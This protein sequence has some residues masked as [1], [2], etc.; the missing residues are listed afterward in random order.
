MVVLMTWIA[1]V[2]PLRPFHVEKNKNLNVTLNFGMWFDI[3]APYVDWVTH[4]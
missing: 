1:W 4:K 2:Y 3:I